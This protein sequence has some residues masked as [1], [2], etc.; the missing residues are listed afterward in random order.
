MSTPDPQTLLNHALSR[1]RAE[2]PQAEQWKALCEFLSGCKLQEQAYLAKN[3]APRLRSFPDA[4]RSAPSS[5]LT[6]LHR[7][8]RVPAL[9]LARALAWK[10]SG[11]D[12]RGLIELLQ[13]PELRNLS[14]LKLFGQAL[15]SKSACWIAQAPQCAKLESLNLTSNRIESQGFRALIESKSLGA[16]RR[17]F[18]GRN[19]LC[20]EDAD[21][22]ISN[23]HHLS[24][25]LLDLR[26]NQ[27]SP[28]L[29]KE[30]S[31]HFE[32]QSVELR[33]ESPPRSEG[34][35][36]RKRG[37]PSKKKPT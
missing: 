28:A 27:F 30:L 20:D 4:V 12:D 32:G 33:L 7:G 8:E 13:Q 1:L 25:E 18:L 3:L 16:L 36:R 35:A 17:L 29:L 5:W 11:L 14:S 22:L 23:K 10:D 9:C 31:Q 19:H 34:L 21:W 26:E 2:Q 24:L 37:R 6:R 15:S